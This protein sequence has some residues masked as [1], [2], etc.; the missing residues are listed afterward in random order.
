MGKILHRGGTLGKPDNVKKLGDLVRKTAE[1]VKA[2]SKANRGLSEKWATIADQDIL[3]HTDVKGINKGVLYVKVDSATWLH[4]ITA[5]KKEGLLKSV[6]SEYRQ[7]Y[8]SDIRFYV[9]NL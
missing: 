1:V 4:Y 9:G 5:F 3:E 8:I 2:R 6:Q 7:R